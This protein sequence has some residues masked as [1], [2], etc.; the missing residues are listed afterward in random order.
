MDMAVTMMLYQTTASKDTEKEGDGGYD[1]EQNPQ[2]ADE[3]GTEVRRR[4]E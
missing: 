3:A 2:P 1:T 4:C